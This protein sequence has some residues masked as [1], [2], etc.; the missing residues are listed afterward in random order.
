MDL[1]DRQR[2]PKSKLNMDVVLD[3]KTPTAY[4]LNQIDDPII[5]AELAPLVEYMALTG[6]SASQIESVLDTTVNTKYAKSTF[7]ADPRFPAGSIK[8]SRYSLEA[9][10]PEED[11]R[12][13]FISAVESQL[14]S[15]YSLDPTVTVKGTTDIGVEDVKRV[16]LVPDEST[17]GLNYFSYFVD[18]NEEL[19]PLIIEQDGQ[20]MWPT[21]DRSDIAD[22]MAKKAS[23]LDSALREQET[24]QKRKFLVREELENRLNPDYVPKTYEDIN[25][26]LEE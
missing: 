25:R 24:E 5:A 2:D 9:V 14:P 19:R 8:R 23:A 20:P 10:F 7:I 21:F 17:A 4:A 16:Y 22:H 18:E 1:I 3:K 13:A 11:D 15:G 6:K 26:A 12:T